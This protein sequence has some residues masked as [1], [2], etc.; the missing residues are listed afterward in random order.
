MIALAKE[1]FLYL[2]QC[3]R[4]FFTGI[5]DSL[6][7]RLA[8]F[9]FRRFDATLTAAMTASPTTPGSACHVPSPNEGIL[10]PVLRAKKL[11]DA[12]I[13]IRLHFPRTTSFLFL[14]ERRSFRP[15]WRVG[16]YVSLFIHNSEESECQCRS[17]AGP[18]TLE[19]ANVGPVFL[20][21]AST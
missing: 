21:P 10:A 6:D 19:L 7:R 16:V 3:G 2:L 15:L 5:F 18:E 12:G 13:A 17:L 11:A 14:D 4:I 20:R 1:R 8:T 9:C